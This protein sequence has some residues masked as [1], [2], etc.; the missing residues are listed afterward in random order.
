VEGG[1]G[2][3]MTSLRTMKVNLNCFAQSVSGVVVLRTG[4]K[5]V[6]ADEFDSDQRMSCSVESGVNLVDVHEVGLTGESYLEAL[7]H[8]R[9]GSVP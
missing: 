2:F 9:V 7:V 6:S 8:I 4:T 5:R 3:V 1:L